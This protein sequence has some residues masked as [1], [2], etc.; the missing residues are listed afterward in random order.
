MQ[1]FGSAS[2]LYLFWALYAF[3]FALLIVFVFMPNVFVFCPLVLVILEI[4][5]QLYGSVVSPQR[6]HVI[7]E[8]GPSAKHIQK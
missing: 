1:V 7:W 6:K 2:T 8:V 4:D 5:Q 3:T